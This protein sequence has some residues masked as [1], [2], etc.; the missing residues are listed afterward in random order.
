MR[1]VGSVWVDDES[2]FDK[3][4]NRVVDLAKFSKSSPAE[5]KRWCRYDYD[6]QTF[7][8]QLNNGQPVVLT[9]RKNQNEKISSQALL[10][11]V[12][13]ELWE[14]GS[15]DFSLQEVLERCSRKI[16][17]DR[18]VIEATNQWFKNTRINLRITIK[19][20]QTKDLMDAFD[21]KHPRSGRYQF[22]IKPPPL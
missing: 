21:T 8:M 5:V 13:Y 14:A 18:L 1:K 15:T 9:F 3:Y 2:V 16:E 17:R 12:G 11:E 10:F 4:K 6:T 19:H 7:T 22:S 20:S